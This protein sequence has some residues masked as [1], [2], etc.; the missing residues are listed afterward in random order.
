MKPHFAGT[1]TMKIVMSTAAA[2]VLSTTALW[3]QG[4]TPE[5]EGGYPTA[6]T[7]EAAFEEFDYQAAT[8]F[9]I[10]AYA[11][12][13][14]LGVDKGMAKFGGSR[15][16]N[17]IF[18]EQIQPQHIFLTANSEVIYFVSRAI[19]IA[20][21]PV[22]FEIPAR[23][24]GHFWDF[25]MRALGDTGDIGPDGGNGGKYLIIARD[26]D[27]PIPEG[28][29]VYRS[30]FSD[31]VMYVGRTFPE[32]E[33]GV[34]AAANQAATARWYPLSQADAPPARETVLIGSMPFSQDW[35]RDAEAFDWLGEVFSTDRA[36]AEGLAH[37]GNMRRLGLTPGETWAPDDR[38]RAILD[39]AAATAEAVVLTMAFQSR[40]TAKVYPD[41]QWE[42]A[43]V[44]KDP[45]FL[46][47]GY[48][49]VEAR[50]GLWHQIIG[51]FMEQ[52]SSEPGTGQFP[53]TTYRDS[54][55][56]FLNGSNTYRLSM[57]PAVPV[58]QF[59]QLPVYSTTNRAL[60][61]TDTGIATKSST[62]ADLILNTDGSVDIIVGPKEPEGE[63][64]WIK[65]NPGEGW[66]TILRLYA[67][68]EP[69]LSRDW[70]PNDIERLN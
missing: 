60:V 65:T 29:T 32:S 6:E 61:Q 66:F 55:G 47:G 30:P 13:N 54:Q 20:E 41:R 36:P 43:F 10:W 63:V 70:V 12:L 25:G 62:D 42:I 48:E 51:N 46:P 4:F 22:V 44:N 53:L 49:E 21:G 26:Y 69:I 35:P 7:A 27:G 37:L 40:L 31:F 17:H 15:F 33:G 2:L 5:Y 68:L 28:Y 52:G 8:Q 59:W 58:A 67:P 9:Y 45:Q 50:A 14:T 3:A 57:P 1:R 38:A 11:Y 19:N 16:A 56:N 23:N 18:S 24:R 64:N 34:E 39:R